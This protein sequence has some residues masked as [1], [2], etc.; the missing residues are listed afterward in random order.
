MKPGSKASSG[1]LLVC[2]WTCLSNSPR[3]VP[4]SSSVSHLSFSP[5]LLSQCIS[6]KGRVAVKRKHHHPYPHPTPPHVLL[7]VGHRVWDSAALCPCFCSRPLLRRT[8]PCT[9]TRHCISWNICTH[10]RMPL[11][12]D[13]SGLQSTSPYAAI[14]RARRRGG[15][16]SQIVSSTGSS[17]GTL[18]Q[19][20]WHWPTQMRWTPGWHP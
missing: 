20:P 16:P 5:Y 8:P 14:S 13:V 2:S 11:C 19:S 9:S 6:K 18:L 10:R 3:F 1:S 15:K 7:V 4:F 12:V 17:A